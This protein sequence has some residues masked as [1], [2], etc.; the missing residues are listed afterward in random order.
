M[1]L[2][3]HDGRNGCNRADS[4]IHFH[5][6]SSPFMMSDHN[7]DM[8]TESDPSETAPSAP[9]PTTDQVAACCDHTVQRT[10]CEP[11]ARP[12]CCTDPTSGS[13]G[14]R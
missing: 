1:P 14:C 9:R 3:T 8:R 11:D 2:K 7:T 10:C 13:C 5:S 12:T 6:G 4:C